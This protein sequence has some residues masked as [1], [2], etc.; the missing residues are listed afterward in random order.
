MLLNLIKKKVVVDAC[1]PR[2]NEGDE[3]SLHALYECKFA[4]DV[5]NMWDAGQKWKQGQ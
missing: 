5:W 1:C 2:C 3:T 4:R